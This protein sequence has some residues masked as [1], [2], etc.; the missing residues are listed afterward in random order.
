MRYI[1]CPTDYYIRRP[2][3]LAMRTLRVLVVDDNLVCA[4]ILEQTATCAFLSN[5][6]QLKATIHTSADAALH[7]LTTNQ[8]D[9]IFTDIEMPPGISGDVM[10]QTIRKD[11][12]DIPIVAVTSKDDAESRVLY[13]SVGITHCLGKPVTKDAILDTACKLN[14]IPNK[15]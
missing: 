13:K 8:Y 9:I 2:A 4:K 12:R 11:D 6:V 15:N 1:N 3:S 7:D 14:L 5:N 10:A